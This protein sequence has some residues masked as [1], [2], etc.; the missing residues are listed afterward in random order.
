M[1]P[2][3]AEEFAGSQ[4]RFQQTEEPEVLGDSRQERDSQRRRDRQEDNKNI[5]G[6]STKTKTRS[7]QSATR[8]LSSKQKTGGAGL[9]SRFITGLNKGG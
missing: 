3:P 6:K 8:G 1:G 9:D 4:T 7:T 2:D 5:A